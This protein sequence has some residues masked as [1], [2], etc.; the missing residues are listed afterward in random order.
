MTSDE[1]AEIRRIARDVDEDLRR[2]INKKAQA[3]K[4]AR[5]LYLRRR[6]REEEMESNW[7]DVAGI[8]GVY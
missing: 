7:F 2:S 5:W 6:K 1:R 3:E 4:I 8:R